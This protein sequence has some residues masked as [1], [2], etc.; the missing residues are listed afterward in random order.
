MSNFFEFTSNMQ[1]TIRRPYVIWHIYKAH[2]DSDYMH[3]LYEYSNAI[4]Y[5]P[6]QHTYIFMHY[7]WYKKKIHE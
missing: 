1:W 7:K 3:I 4:Q 2:K 5:R 6:I